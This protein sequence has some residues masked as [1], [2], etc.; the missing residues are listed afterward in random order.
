[1]IFVFSLT[2]MT[3]FWSVTSGWSS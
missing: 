1:M 3:T 2:F